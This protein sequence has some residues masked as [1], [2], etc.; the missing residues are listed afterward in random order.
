MENGLSANLVFTVIQDKSGYIWLSTENGLNRYDGYNFKVFRHNPNDPN[1]P[2]GAL[3]RAIHQDGSGN[4]WLGTFSNGLDLYDPATQGFRQYRHVAGDSNSIASDSIWTLNSTDDGKL[5]IGTY[6]AGIDVLDTKTGRITHRPAHS[7][8]AAPTDNRINSIFIDHEKHVWLGTGSGLDEFDPD[9]LIPT[10]HFTVCGGATDCSVWGVA[11]DDQHRLWIAT[12]RGPYLYIPGQA[13]VTHVHFQHGDYAALDNTFLHS[14]MIDDKG[15]IWF[16]SVLAGVF[17]VHKGD[18][19]VQQFGLQVGNVSDFSS[20]DVWGL[21]EDSAGIVWIA[22]DTGVDLVDPNILNLNFIKPSAVRNHP[23]DATDSVTAVAQYKNDILIGSFGAIYQ[24]P[25]GVNSMDAVSL[26]TTVDRKHFGEVRSLYPD[27]SGGLYAGTQWGY[28]LRLDPHGHIV[29]SRQPINGRKGRDIHRILKH[30]DDSFYLATFGNG[31]LDYDW[32]SG[33]A[34]T[35]TGPDRTSLQ[36]D[37][38]VEDLLAPTPER[39]WAGTFRGLFKVDTTTNRSIQ[40]PMTPGN[41]EPVVQGLY[42]DSQHTLWVATYDGLWKIHL[43]RNGDPVS[44][45]EPLPALSHIQLLSVQQDSDGSLWLGT[46]NSLIRFDPRDGSMLTLGG[47]QGSPI[48]EYY[49]YGHLRDSDGHLWYG[50][51][52]GALSFLPQLL[53][54]NRH[55]PQ[56]IMSDAIVYRDGKPQDVRISAGSALTLSY[57]DVITTFDVSAADF[58]SSTAN[59]YSY[60]LVGFQPQWTPPSSEHLITFTNLNPGRYRLEVRAANNWGTWSAVPAALELIVLPPWWRTWWAYT[61]YLLIIIGSAIAY[62]YSLKRKI[63]REKAV[64]AS[65][66]EANEIKSNFVEKLEV[67]VREAT[68]ELRETLQGVNLKNAELEIAQRRA[69]EGEQVKS[70][71]LAN[72]SHELRT[73]LTGVLGYTKL[74]TS[75]NLNSEQKDY[76]GTIRVSSEALLAIINDTL[77]LS[78]LE[79]GKLLIDEVDF[80]LLELIESTLE[81]LAPIAYQK[82]LELIRVVPPD[83]PL[84]LR[85][86]PLRMRQVLTNLLSNAIKFTESGSVC[87]EVNV[88]EQTERDATIGFRIVDTGIGIPEGEIGQLF[89]AYNRG[90]ISTR[91]QVEGT[92][93]GLAICKKL[94]DLMG[95]TVGVE[96]RVGVGST[97]HFQVK[98]RLQK[99][100]APRQQLPR[101]LSILLYDKHPLSNAAWKASLT[102]L[103][104]DVR[105]VAELESLMALQAEAAVL[106]LSERELAHLG[107]LKQKFSPALPPMLILAPRI[108]RQTLKDLSEALYHRVLSKTAREKTVYLELQSLVQHAIHTPEPTAET[109]PKP[110][111][112]PAP[113]A[114]APLVLVADDNRINRRLLV[115]MLNQSGFRTAEAG[116]GIELLDLAARGPF[117]A[118]ILDIHMPGMDGI[119]TATRLR[120]AYGEQTPPIIA[121]SADVLPGGPGGPQQGLMD[122][123]LMKPFNEQQLVDLLRMHIERYRRRREGQAAG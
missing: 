95:G 56:V 63:V 18:D 93:L 39:L 46:I 55:P 120:I 21:Y 45:P 92:G 91:H 43:D 25:L 28:L 109:R 67:Q 100:A 29:D 62:V 44:S 22:T 122:D 68:Q 47:A 37:D 77:D 76:V 97:F 8:P 26:F 73:P 10:R 19:F 15:N 61:I 82:R 69:A 9:G 66:R 38:I 35:I 75:T 12:Q 110:S 51:A 58:G 106:S 36:P 60:R 71:F 83:A 20:N 90:R 87:L 99:H 33:R 123:F 84:H 7:G 50:G 23:K 2:S 54:P 117:Q 40:I 80:D 105:D 17:L 4:I 48:T 72:M 70:Q 59:T 81:L 41:I 32:H 79:A 102:R 85:G 119:E 103:G 88:L 104:A 52:Q 121:M 113:A 64:S 74:L 115:T 96:S 118:A 31:L 13:T 34:A 78:R 27:D 16:G 49:S 57:K 114:D 94:L 112:A 1:S 14:V 24:A 111:V 86:D 42:E 107:E 5:L 30:G 6:D 116:N 89:N 108:D 53:R 98:F 65:L 3:A 101:K 11:E